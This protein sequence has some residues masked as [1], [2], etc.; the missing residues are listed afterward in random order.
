VEAGP[1]HLLRALALLWAR[2]GSAQVYVAATVIGVVALAG[3]G[4]WHLIS[5]LKQPRPTAANISNP[6][7]GPAPPTPL[8]VV[9]PGATAIARISPGIEPSS[10]SA[11]LNPPSS[12]SS[13]PALER[14]IA[15]TDL[16]QEERRGPRGETLVIGTIG[17]TSRSDAEK[18]A[19]EI[20]VSF[21]DLTP[22]N[23][24]RPTNARVTYRWL[25]PIRDWND[26]E[27][28]FLEAA[29]FK[30][31]PPRWLQEKLRYGGFVVRVY[32][33]G[34]LQD[35]RSKPETLIASLRSN[36]PPSSPSATLTPPPS[37]I[38]NSPSSPS[39][40]PPPS[41]TLA[42]PAMRDGSPSRTPSPS[43]I[44]NPPSSPESRPALRDGSPTNHSSPVTDHSSESLPKGIPVPGKPGFVSSPYDPKFLIDVRGFPPGTLVNDPNTNK[45]FRVP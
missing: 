41:A 24:M 21:F 33:D 3:V 38:L 1:K 36:A 4:V 9:A 12:P 5:P 14:N 7:P 40:R 45:P 44:L 11:I 30:P 25:T 43:A 23:E 34:K 28:K 10:P 18:G 22:N 17:L 16:T 13:A 42:R 32:A 26:P 8:P 15:I 37:S 19:V 35:E 20:R 6:T 27:P 29:Y 31:R 39:S 2:L